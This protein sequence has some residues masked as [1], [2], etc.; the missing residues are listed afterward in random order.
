[1][2]LS[3]REHYVAVIGA[4]GVGLSRCD[5]RGR[6]WL[7]SAGF[8]AD[9][10]SAPALALDS[11]Q[12]LL[13]EHIHRRA[14]LSVLFS[15]HYSRFGLIPWSEHITTPA[16]LQAY[17]S[18]CFD[19]TFGKSSEAWALSLSP[20]NA[21]LPRIAV[22]LPQALLNHLRTLVKELGLQLVSVQPYLMAAFNRFQKSF[23]DRDFL[24]VVAEPG[25]STLLLA[26]EGR[27]SA[28]RSLRIADSDAA[29]ASMIARESEL[30][31]LNGDKPVDLF[32]HAP[33]RHNDGP[34]ILGVQ[35]LELPVVEGDV[36]DPLHLMARA[37]N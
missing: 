18:A 4:N 34:M 14:R 16:E 29:L 9:R 30:H 17:A 7:G 32:V 1:M 13:A 8:I 23:G 33:A 3:F 22:A 31:G 21:G 2:S 15:S 24:F 12:R 37:V 27:W 35:T 6:T 20:E 26:R 5:A 28:V 36:Q 11:L 19:D 10:Q 25:R